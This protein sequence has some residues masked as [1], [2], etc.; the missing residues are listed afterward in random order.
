MKDHAQVDLRGRD[1]ENQLALPLEPFP[2]RAFPQAIPQE[3]R[4]PDD[5]IEATILSIHDLWKFEWPMEW[6]ARGP[7]WGVFG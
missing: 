2:Q 3:R 7:I 1:S 4:I 6:M 5:G